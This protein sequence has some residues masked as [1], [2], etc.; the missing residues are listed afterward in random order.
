[1]IHNHVSALVANIHG[2]SASCFQVPHVL[3][4]WR[5]MESLFLCARAVGERV[6]ASDP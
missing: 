5:K 4:S 1:M 2:A 6:I 3:V